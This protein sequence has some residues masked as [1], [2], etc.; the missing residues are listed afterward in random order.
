M[1]MILVGSL[2]IGIAVDNTIHFMHNFRRY[3][4]RDQNVELAVHN[5]LI[6]AGRA[7]FITSIVLASGFFLYMGASMESIKN[8]GFITGV[9]VIMAFLADVT[10]SP[11]LVC[12][13]MRG[14]R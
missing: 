10:L 14:R 2:A 11:A 5:T 6:T 4:R 1:L 12:I 13:A 9:T 7:L 3:Y 8:F